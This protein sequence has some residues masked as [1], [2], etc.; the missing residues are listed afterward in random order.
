MGIISW[1]IFGGLAGWVASMITG[2]NDQ[3]GCLSN[4][5]AGVVGAFV[6]GAI[7]TFLTGNDFMAGFNVVSFIVAVIGA[8]LVLALLNLL[9]GRRR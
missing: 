8:V 1:I 4:I 6:G 2:R 9:T 7:Y 3:M 5:I